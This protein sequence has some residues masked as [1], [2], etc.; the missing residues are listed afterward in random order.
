MKS[1]YTITYFRI[2]K[3]FKR[4]K[5]DFFY[6][7]FLGWFHLV[8]KNLCCARLIM[9][10]RPSV[11]QNGGNTIDTAGGNNPCWIM[12]RL[13]VQEGGVPRPDYSTTRIYMRLR[14]S[15]PRYTASGTRQQG[16]L[17]SFPPQYSNSVTHQQGCSTALQEYVRR[18][19]VPASLRSTSLQELAN[20]APTPVSVTLPATPQ[21]QPQ[22]TANL[23]A[24]PSSTHC[25]QY[26][27]ASI[28]ALKSSPHCY[29]HRT[30]II[31]ARP[32]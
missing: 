30:A 21:C 14:S 15:V 8:K 12:P 11:S 10:I 5:L 26:R 7:N 31:T 18:V 25:H 13:A 6:F 16:L 20:R 32:A 23:T 24:L 3:N 9:M 29:Y 4:R 22:R 19:P 28:A 1:Y 27:T 17:H 2:T